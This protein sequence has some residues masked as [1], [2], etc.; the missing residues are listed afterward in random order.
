MSARRL[1]KLKVNEPCRLVKQFGL[2]VHQANFTGDVAVIFA[3][4]G[5]KA[6]ILIGGLK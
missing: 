3:F 4:D 1:V 2:S 5:E 6:P